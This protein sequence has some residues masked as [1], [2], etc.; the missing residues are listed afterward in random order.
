MVKGSRVSLVDGDGGYYVAVITEAQ[1]RQCRLSIEEK[2]NDYGKKSYR[3]H[4]AI[5]PTKNNERLEWFVEKAT[6]IGIDEITPLLSLRSERKTVNTDRLEKIMISAMKQSERAYLPRLNKLKP[7]DQFINS[8]HEGLK[9]IA[10]CNQ[11]EKTLLKNSDVKNKKV[12]IMVGPEGDFTDE[13]VQRAMN[14]G[15]KE[16]SLGSSRLRT[17]TAGIVA[18]HTVM[19]LND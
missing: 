13:E 8:T 16:I 19:L 14:S 5:A 1:Q 15:F 3:L 4:I 9:Y 12:T 2:Q 10:H 7:F 17:E 18:C 11:G 6:E